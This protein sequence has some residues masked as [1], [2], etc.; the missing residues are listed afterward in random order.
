MVRSFL[1]GSCMK[2]RD[3]NL[4]I[5]LSAALAV[6]VLCKGYP[7]QMAEPQTTTVAEHFSP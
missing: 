2:R 6:M 5:F 3:R 7:T 4:I 1:V